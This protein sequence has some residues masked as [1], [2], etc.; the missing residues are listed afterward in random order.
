MSSLDSGASTPLLTRLRS[1]LPM[2]GPSEGRVV[3]ALIDAPDSSVEWSTAELAAVAHTSPATV[4]RA[5]QNLG[6][7]GY[8][9]LRL[10]LARTPARPSVESRHMVSTIFAEAADAISVSQESLSTADFD[11]AATALSQAGRVLMVGTGFSSPP[12]QDAALRFLTAGRP[13]DAPLDVQ[14]Q[15]FAARL[16]KE[17]DVCLAVSYSGA[18]ANTLKACSAAKDGGGAT[19][20]AITSFARSP[21]TRLADV[22]L[23][24]GPVT[25]NHD[26]DPHLSRI[27]H[28]LVLHALQRA[29]FAQP[30]AE[31]LMTSMRDVVAD[32]LTDGFPST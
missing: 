23:V 19:V 4:I 11:R 2:L 22:S 10:E 29:V 8:Q 5:C 28:G 6:F 1:A 27:S 25:R 3:K 20:I 16:L 24:T 32:S 31:S 9:H 7:R 26:V 12:I 17:G 14:A 30:G 18:N 13:V 15:Q 21:L